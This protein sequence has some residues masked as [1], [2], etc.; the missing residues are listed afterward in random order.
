MQPRA[1][2][3]GDRPGGPPLV[4]S[5]FP[6]VDLLGRAFAAAG[7]AV[8]LG[9]DLLWDQRIEDFH[10]PP[11]RF[12]GIIGGPPC[13]HYSDANRHRN[14]AEGDRLLSE[15]LRIVLEAQPEWFLIENVRNVPTCEF[16]YCKVQ[17][18]SVDAW[19]FGCRAARLRHIQFG[20]RDG[21][22]I[23]PVRP[24][25]RRPVTLAPTLTTARDGPGDRFS[26]RCAK[27]GVTEL[28]L[29]ALTPAAR[30]RAIGNGVPY[31]MG[32]ALA[33]AVVRRGPVTD[34]DCT[35]GCGREVPPGRSLATVACRQRVS[36]CRRGHTRVL[37]YGCDPARG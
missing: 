1:A 16:N 34:R 4:L 25:T 2:A 36:R 23:R 37:R 33:E 8:V 3:D 14:P 21:H 18:L 32:L 10:V 22:I 29:S 17:R 12:D 35:C 27:M 30:R 20:H 7:H 11:G 9:P 19:E 5:L 24:V 15:F 6:G 13:V 28:K 26:R 31:P